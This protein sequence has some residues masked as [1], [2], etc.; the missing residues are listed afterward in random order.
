MRLE[1]HSHED[2][3]RIIRE[4]PHWP[5][6][7]GTLSAIG[8]DDILRQHATYARPPAGA[9]SA[10]ND[11]IDQ[12]LRALGWT[13]QARLFNDPAL[14]TWT[15]DFY[16]GS[17][18]VE[19]VFNNDQYVP[20]ELQRLMLA[21]R[22]PEVQG[23]HRTRVGV[24]VIATKA[25]KAWGKL[26]GS[27]AT[28]EKLTQVWLPHLAP[29]LTFPI[30]AI[31]LDAAQGETD[32]DPN[33]SPFRGTKTKDELFERWQQDEAAAAEAAEEGVEYDA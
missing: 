21:K 22:S 24:V 25:L 19:V 18:G 14:P 33:Q 32:W 28:Y 13:G 9:Q 29:I 7:T 10:I 4:E 2:A 23:L 16:K 5:E 11:V 8:R 17:V 15:M 3:D 31:G 12:R 6:L 26:D 30:M 20:W 1:Y 27:C